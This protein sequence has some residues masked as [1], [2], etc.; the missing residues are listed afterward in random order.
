MRQRT[1][2][3]NRNALPVLLA[4][5]TLV[6][7]SGSYPGAT[8]AGPGSPGNPG[9]PGPTPTYPFLSE[10]TLQPS[11]APSI[12]V[13]GTVLVG[14]NAAYQDSAT[15]ISYKD[16]TSSATWSTSKDTV[17]TVEKGLVTGNGIGSATITASFGGKT[18]TTLVVVG[19]TPAL[20]VTS[21]DKGMFSLT[22]NPDQHFQVTASYSDG[23]VL[24]LTV[25]VTWGSSKPEILKFFNDYVHDVGE[26]TLLTTGTT[27]ITATMDSG[28]VGSLDVTVVP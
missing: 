21:T 4:L 24:D 12:A 15:Q 1:S 18:A 23:N 14:A 13:A 5:L 11:S 19:Q 3:A 26:A 8:P 16:V 17:A 25:Y 20:D 7:C 27:T 6:A 10:V 28:E 9:N 2:P 22:A